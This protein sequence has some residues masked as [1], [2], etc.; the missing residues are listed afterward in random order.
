MMNDRL[1]RELGD[2]ARKE[3]E[4]EQAR[5]DERWDRLAAGT[6]TAEEETELRAL[7][8]S[9]PEAGEA[10][11]AFKPLGA[12]FQ[13]RVAS[14]INSQR[15]SEAPASEPREERPRVLP[16]RRLARRMEVWIGAAA[17]VA[18][19]AFFLVRGP[20]LPVPFAYEARFNAGDQTLRGGEPGPA[21]GIPTFSSGSRLE[22]NVAPLHPIPGPVEA[23]AFLSSSTGEEDLKPW[24]PES[25][26]QIAEKGGAVRLVGTLGQ[27]LQLPSGD[28]TVWIVVARP[29]KTPGAGEIQA[30]LRSG[31]SPHEPWRSVCTALSAAP[32]RPAPWQAS[33]AELRVVNHSSS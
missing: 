14:A 10:Y 32:S 9:S 30:R 24:K 7:A 2:L 6:L 3:A 1:L 23:Q 28:W 13:A 11:A 20:A 15:A 12:E 19:G 26:F 16:F 21:N 17:A 25:P 5:L 31:R 18:A 27:D 8:T 29:R 22:L 4:A 33:C